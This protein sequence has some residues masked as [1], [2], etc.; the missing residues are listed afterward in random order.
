MIKISI[1]VPAYNAEAYLGRCVE[2]LMNQTIGD[3]EIILVDDGSTDRTPELCDHYAD[4]CG[5]VKAIHIA[6]GGPAKARNTG[7]E[8]A[9]GLYIGFAD[10]DD[11]MD[12]DMFRKLY[13]KAAETKAD[14]VFSDYIRMAR[15][16][17]KQFCSQDIG[18]GYYSKE[19]I[20]QVLFPRLIMRETID[21]G[22]CL[23]VWNGIYR[24]QFLN[25][26]HI[27]F[28]PGLRWTEDHLFSSMAV[29][30]CSSLYYLK[31]EYLYHYH[32]N[33]DSI[34]TSY[35]RGAW[36]VSCVLNRRFHQFFDGVPDY[37]FSGQVALSTVYYALNC[38]QQEKKHYG[39][40]SRGEI[41]RILH[42]EELQKAFTDFRMPPVCLKLKVILFLMRIRADR[43]IGLYCR[44]P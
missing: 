38:I 6:N 21:H 31:N 12:P 40:A 17:E 30:S 15:S 35:R 37:D 23:P 14:Y 19:K 26:L 13:E 1:I 27:R 28:D 5:S 22:P 41:R 8:N 43:M 3:T 11:D 18:A 9:S 4:T 2:S 7:I 16:S 39:P 29:Y 36:D 25:D 44:L 33:R 34:T 42:S 32:E 20:R 24:R 10:A